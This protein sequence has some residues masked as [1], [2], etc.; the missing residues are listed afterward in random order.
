M[1]PACFGESHTTHTDKHALTV[2]HTTLHGYTLTHTLTLTHTG[3]HTHTDTHTLTHVSLHTVGPTHRHHTTHA[4][5]M[6]RR[7]LYSDGYRP[8][9]P[10][11]TALSAVNH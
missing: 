7:P 5:S 6:R 4:T 2:T 11:V 9:E 1:R 3:T 8:L 10:P